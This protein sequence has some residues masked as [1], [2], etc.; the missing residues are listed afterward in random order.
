MISAGLRIKAY[1][2][3]FIGRDKKKEFFNEWFI[4]FME[5]IGL[6][7]PQSFTSKVIFKIIHNYFLDVVLAF[8]SI[9]LFFYFE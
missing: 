5:F 3:F 1:A 4:E 6:R 7:V 8:E 9:V 2:Y